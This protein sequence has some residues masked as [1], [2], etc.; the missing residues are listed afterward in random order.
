MVVDGFHLIEGDLVIDGMPLNEVPEER[1]TE[2]CSIV[3]ERNKAF[4]W[5]LGYEKNY[6][7]VITVN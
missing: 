7:A 3:R 2:I 5:L 6:A 4:R 1:V